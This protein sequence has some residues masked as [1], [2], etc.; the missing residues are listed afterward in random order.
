MGRVRR[1][2]GVYQDEWFNTSLSL[3]ASTPQPSPPQLDG[4]CM[5]TVE[6]SSTLPTELR[7]SM[8]KEW[9]PEIRKAIYRLYVVDDQSLSEVKTLVE[10]NFGFQATERQYK[11]KIAAW[12]LDKNIKDEEMRA[13]ISLQRRRKGEEGKESIFYVRD[14]LVD[15]R[16]INRFA[17]RKAVGEEASFSGSELIESLSLDI[18][19]YTPTS[20]DPPK[21][22]SR[23]W[24]N[25]HSNDQLGQDADVD[26]RSPELVPQP[27]TARSSD[28]STQN[29]NKRRK[30]SSH[31]GENSGSAAQQSAEAAS[32]TMNPTMA[33]QYPVSWTS[34]SPQLSNPTNPQSL[35]LINDLS[36][37]LSPSLLDTFSKTVPSSTKV[38]DSNFHGD[39]DLKYGI[40]RGFPDLDL[41]KN[42][43]NTVLGGLAQASGIVSL[44]DAHPE[45]LDNAFS[46]ATGVSGS[47]IGESR[48]S[49]YG[50]PVIVSIPVSFHPLPSILNGNPMNLLY[51]HHFLNHTART[52]V[53]HD[54]SANPFRNVLPRSKY[55]LII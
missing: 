44:D 18:Q 32:A 11:R 38:K 55:K 48:F 35:S 6:P 42:P 31:L 53:A 26:R 30:T 28:E 50:K 16:K 12:R 21:I 29:S 15:K 5:L 45:S 41:P 40:D 43:D 37:R 52:L 7:Q 51:F 23:R 39:R 27:A 14:R 22:R 33:R 46:E 20:K 49:Y 3:S 54:C 8:S 13:I 2:S 25:S 24:S 19:C 10:Q 36:K 9:D 17:Q 1:L 4:A 47:G 34:I